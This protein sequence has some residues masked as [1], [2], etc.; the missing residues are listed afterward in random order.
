MKK[1]SHTNSSGKYRNN[2]GY[3][4]HFDFISSFQHSE[5]MVNFANSRKPIIFIIHVI[6]LYC[7]PN[8]KKSI[9]RS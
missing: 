3:N 8:G 5:W 9:K 2:E 7:T 1:V 4:K 6:S